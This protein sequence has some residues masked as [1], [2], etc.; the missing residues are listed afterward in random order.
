MGVLLLLAPVPWVL[1]GCAG[2]AAA[3]PA[4]TVACCLVLHPRCAEVAAALD[5]P[6]GQS[7]PKENTLLAETAVV[8]LVWTGLPAASLC[9][10]PE[11]YGCDGLLL[12]VLLCNSHTSRTGEQALALI[13]LLLSAASQKGR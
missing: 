1:S 9:S 4:D 6:S 12:P 2:E 8:P 7:D 11:E 3:R 13:K 10:I 5:G